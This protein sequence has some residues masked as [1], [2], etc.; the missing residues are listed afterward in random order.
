MT[1][2]FTIVSGPI[3]RAAL[4]RELRNAHAGACVT[5]EGWVRDLNEGRDVS[6]LEYEAFAP[7][8]EKEGARILAEAREKFSLAGAAGA[9]RVGRLVPGDL[10]VWIGVT[11]AHRDAAFDACRYIIDEVKARLP[12]W[13]KEHYTG[14]AEPRWINCATC[15][16]HA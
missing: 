14:G 11:S 5:F 15:G 13:K 9:H 6:A 7:L 2:I 1:E 4:Q 10:A 16:E 12:V 8:A 3:D